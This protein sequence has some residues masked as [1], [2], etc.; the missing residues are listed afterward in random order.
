[1]KYVI[2]NTTINILYCYLAL[3][4]LQYADFT[5]I[6]QTYLKKEKNIFIKQNLIRIKW[7]HENVSRHTTTE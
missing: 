2:K 5:S 4:Q 3:K 1:M 6:W 7:H